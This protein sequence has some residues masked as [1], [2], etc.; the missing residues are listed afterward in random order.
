MLSITAE[1]I[2]PFLKVLLG[3]R[4]HNN[5]SHE[6]DCLSFSLSYE[7]KSISQHKINIERKK[8]LPLV[9]KL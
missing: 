9:L 6:F 7:I 1:A 8:L 2:Y 3:V 4:E 5:L